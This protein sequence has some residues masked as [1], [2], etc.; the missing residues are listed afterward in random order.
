MFT[1]ALYKA[2][3]AVTA[4]E[5]ASELTPIFFPFKSAIVLIPESGRTSIFVQ[6]V[7]I[8]EVITMFKPFSIG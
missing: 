4:S 2:L 1:P 8:P 6:P 3:L 5:L 7:C